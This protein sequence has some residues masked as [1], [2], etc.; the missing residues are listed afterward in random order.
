MKDAVSQ[1]LYSYW[2]EVRGDRLA[3]QRFEIEPSR[4]ASILPDT[5]ILE[6]VDGSASRFRLAGT[7]ICETFGAEFRGVN[8]LDLFGEA[9]R[10][11]LRR[12]LAVIARQGACGLLTIA[13]QSETGLTANF[14]MLILPLFHTRDVVDRFI[15]AMVPLAPEPWLGT[16]PLTVKGIV[17]Q[18]LIWPDGRAHAMIDNMHHQPPFMPHIREARIVRSDRR[19]FRVYDGGLGK[20]G[21]D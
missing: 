1:A 13:T 4:I 10:V 17:E 5:F 12:Q 16:V 14:E 20:P 18:E 9:D 15:G 2:N 8:V 11:G 6:R 3:P 7:R 19:Q 21:K